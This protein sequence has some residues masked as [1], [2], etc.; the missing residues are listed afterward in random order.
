MLGPYGG[1]VESR[2]GGALEHVSA[3]LAALIGGKQGAS[4][5]PDL[6][7]AVDREDVAVA[8]V[9]A[10]VEAPYQGPLAVSL[11]SVGGDL[12]YDADLSHFERLTLG[13]SVSDWLDVLSQVAEFAAGL[14]SQ[15][16]A[17]GDLRVGMLF[18][19]ER[20]IAI[21]VPPPN[22][23][24]AALLAARLRSGAHP[25]EVAYAAPE[26]A[27][28][29]PA[30]PASDVYS[31]AALAF[32]AIGGRA[33]LALVDARAQLS[34]LGEDTADT[35]IA[36]LDPQ[37]DR[38]PKAELLAR[39]LRDAVAVQ[40]AQGAN[41]GAAPEG[42]SIFGAVLLV[43]AVAVFTGVFGLAL[44]RFGQVAAST[45]LVSFSVF[46]LAV[47]GAG[48]ALLRFGH[49]RSGLGLC[50]LAA[51]L[52]WADAWL[53]LAV[54]GLERSYAAW[55]I[56]G[57]AIGVLQV[58]LA[59]RLGWVLIGAFGAL[60]FTISATTLGLF[61][62][63]G[64]GHGPPAFAATVALGLFVAELG[65]SRWRATAAPLSVASG[66]WI[67]ASAI[68]SLFPL[69]AGALA[70]LAW[71]YALVVVS[72][73][74]AAKV[75]ERARFFRLAAMSLLLVAPSLQAGVLV[76]RGYSIHFAGPV[77][78]AIAVAV[79]RA[80]MLGWSLPLSIAAAAWTT[81]GVVMAMS[82]AEPL[83]ALG[84]YALVALVATAAH[85]AKRC[86]ARLAARVLGVTAVALLVVVPS[87]QALV[88]R[89]RTA[90]MAAVALFGALLL[91]YVVSKKTRLDVNEERAVVAIGLA[92]TTLSPAVLALIACMGHS[93][94]QLGEKARFGGGERWTYLAACALVS[95][96]LFALTF[97]ANGLRREHRRALEFAA[98]GVGA[99]VAVLLSFPAAAEDLFY[100]S[101]ALVLGGMGL[102]VALLR[103]RL[104]L[105]LTSATVIV[106]V[107]SVQYFAKLKS[108]LHWGVL[109]VGFGILVLLLAAL[110]ERKLK[111]LL[112][113]YSRWD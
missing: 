33:P 15:A 74:L 51:Q 96:F 2:M 8:S 100:S 73:A 92:A 83:P 14:H 18:R 78:L 102:T 111:Q 29:S 97:A 54:A 53:L 108:A 41:V 3:E 106:L 17:H 49:R 11:R 103:W 95:T 66:F 23:D 89:E 40:R 9:P 101:L 60:A 57:A 27:H 98:L 68:S 72:L 16:R 81:A 30:T 70:A 48:A 1:L 44:T 35:L 39:A 32:A 25:T 107:L 59:A 86:S 63:I 67:A 7:L 56:A 84:V 31:L 34:H 62:P 112:P 43:G 110:Y 55:A 80:G 87:V 19:R 64:T 77:M 13:G 52:L 50:A 36:A 46:T 37:P 82:Q 104:V 26:V 4:R 47:F 76:A 6:R 94:S 109:A 99:G 5:R 12:E 42:A 85:I 113:D 79:T 88:F 10:D 22:V 38:R 93:A 28:G 69:A 45:R 21:V 71:P 105:A 24:A 58:A 61:L 91:A 65:L 20:G 90:I 75:D